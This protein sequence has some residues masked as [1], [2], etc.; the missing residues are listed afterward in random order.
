[1]DVSNKNERSNGRFPLVYRKHIVMPTEHGS[2]A[3]LLVPFFVGTAV[4]GRFNLPVLLALLG[5]LAVFFL[6]QPATV[7]LRVQRKKAR[8]ADGPI[9]LAWIGLF[10]TVG[11]LCLAGLL[12]MER[13][14][15]AW[16]LGP[17]VLIFGLY[18]VAARYG[19]S[20][21]RSLWMELA[22]AA[23]LSMMAPA[24]AIAA[25]GQIETWMWGLWGLM[26]AQNVLG[27]L[28]VRLR[29]YDTHNRS[30][31]RWPIAT[32]HLAGFLLVLGL[33]LGNFVPVLTAVPFAL[34]FIRSLWAV[35]TVRPVVNIKKFGFTELGLEI[36]SGLWLI[37]A[38][39]LS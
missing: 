32:A 8:A 4:A 27:A 26:A 5:G 10:I 37:A 14:M 29:V 28:Y 6:R 36:V 38:Y 1:M 34:F 13:G 24:A 35:A 25:A 22:G 7:W 15:L 19:R 20:G 30:M 2:W 3:W 18:M 16:L 23:A 21:L 33:G 17:F 11:L 12:L 31:K 39:W 9:A